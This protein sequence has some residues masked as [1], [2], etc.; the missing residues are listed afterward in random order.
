MGRLRG[1]GP[2]RGRM[3]AG[4][5][6]RRLLG[7]LR[8]YGWLFGATMLVAAL[9]SVL[10][11]VVMVLL[12][13]FLRTLFREPALAGIG[14]SSTQAFL[15]RVLGWLIVAGSPEASLRNV[16]LVILATLV[17]KNGADYASAYWNVVIQEGVVRDLRE[18][19]SA[20]S[21]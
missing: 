14:T 11:G 3:S 15:E 19:E 4:G 12:I 20:L 8:P 1:R 7:L 16:V 9:A 21:S 6:A 13:P 10:D 17:L 5:P 18:I 2:P